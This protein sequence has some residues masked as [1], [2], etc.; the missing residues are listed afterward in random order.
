M[1]SSAGCLS[2]LPPASQQIRY[3]T[4]D[5]PTERL[6]EPEYRRWLPAEH[7]LPEIEHV[8]GVDDLNWIYVTPGD[9]GHGELGVEFSIGR[10]VVQSYI[11]YV[12][13]GIE[14]Y[15]RLVGAG[16]L[17][18]VIE[19]SVDRE[20]LR[21]TLDETRYESAGTYEG[22]EL[23]DR[24]DIPRLIAITD[25]VIVHSRGDSRRAKMETLVDAG[26]GRIDRWHETDDDFAAYTDMLG[27]APT[28]MDEF[29]LLEDATFSGLTYTFDGSAAYFQHKHRF[30]PG[31]AP[32]E[33]AVK[34]EIN[35]LGRGQR[36][37]LVDVTIDDPTVVVTLR[38]TDTQWGGQ[39]DRERLPFV[40]WGVDHTDETVTVL[41]EAGEP[42]PVDNLDIRPAGALREPP[43]AGS[44]LEPGDELVFDVDELSR[45]VDDESPGGNTT[46]MTADSI[47]FVFE[48]SDASTSMLF[49]YDPSQNETAT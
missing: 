17:G 20:T 43:A 7:E 26:A 46:T 42:V 47:R 3:G 34:T 22:Y 18:A 21:A 32:D 29:G 24:T 28:V 33:G 49:S 19:A 37:S 10:D 12:G 48:L 23:F 31:T 8:D 16:S 35:G 9:L 14:S 15:D 11:D 41:H 39:A 38:L 25:D 36:A 4:V 40:T 2:L 1:G 27:S 44:L 6:G 45:T 30:R 13:F 5:V